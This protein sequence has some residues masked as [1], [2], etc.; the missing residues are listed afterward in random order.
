VLQYLVPLFEQY[1]VQL[2]LSGNSHNYERSYPLRGGNVV[3]SGGVTYVVSGAGGNG[4][5]KF[6]IAQPSWSAYREASYYEYTKVTVSPTSL[7]VDAVR[8]D[9]NAVFDSTTI[10]AP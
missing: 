6:T 10:Q 5:N 8:A 3:S 7:Q 2:V 4:F 9:T 1:N